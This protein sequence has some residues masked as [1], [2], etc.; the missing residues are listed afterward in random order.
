M[1][2]RKNGFKLVMALVLGAVVFFLP[3]PEGTKFKISGD[4]AGQL[5]GAVGQYFDRVAGEGPAYILEAKA[6]GAKEARAGFLSRT[7]GKLGMDKVKVDYVDGMSPK[8]KRFLAILAVLVALFVVEPIP[9]EI[10][11]LMIGAS[12]VVLGITDV[13]G[14]WAP[15]MHPV[16]IFIMCCLIFAIAKVF[17]SCC[18]KYESSSSSPYPTSSIAWAK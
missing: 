15:Y 1:I 10:T 14:A 12:L 13:K 11:A 3:R 9:L 16:V 7:A 2:L 4:G 8:A 6:P 17:V 18:R 5:S